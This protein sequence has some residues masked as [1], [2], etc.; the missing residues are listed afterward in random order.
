MS[1]SST[2]SKSSSSSSGLN[3]LAIILIAFGCVASFGVVAGVV[4]F[5]ATSLGRFVS[6]RG[7][8]DG[9]VD[10][11]ELGKNNSD[12][13]EQHKGIQFQAWPLGSPKFIRITTSM[14]Q[15]MFKINLKMK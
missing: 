5:V 2:N 11:H 12:Q 10:D 7:C 1:S 15:K 13:S 4:Y 3:T 8:S 14:F 9:H 6:S